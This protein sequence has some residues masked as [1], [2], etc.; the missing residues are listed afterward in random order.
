MGRVPSATGPNVRNVLVSSVRAYGGWQTVFWMWG[1]DVVCVAN[2]AFCERD[3]FLG[4]AFRGRRLFNCILV[5]RSRRSIVT[6][7]GNRGRASILQDL[8]FARMFEYVQLDCVCVCAASRQVWILRQVQ[9]LVLYVGITK[10]DFSFG[11][12]ALSDC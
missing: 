3:V 7:L 10:C 11:H 1:R 8:I 6:N 5:F 12:R 9:V 2:T 4:C